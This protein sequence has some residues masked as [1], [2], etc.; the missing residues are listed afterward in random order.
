M[1]NYLSV[2]NYN[3]EEPWGKCCFEHNKEQKMQQL[4]KRKM[5]CTTGSDSCHRLEKQH[6]P[7]WCSINARAEAMP[8]NSLKPQTSYEGT[9]WIWRGQEGMCFVTVMVS[10]IKESLWPALPDCFEVSSLHVPAE[11]GSLSP[12][13][14][15]LALQRPFSLQTNCSWLSMAILGGRGVTTPP[16]P[17]TARFSS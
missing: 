16:T 13:S 14:R 7:E 6:P 12:C 5:S 17:N 15:N 10:V 1:V 9:S 3:L 8:E 4:S 2:K 11:P